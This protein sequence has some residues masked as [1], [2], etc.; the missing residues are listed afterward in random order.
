[1]INELNLKGNELII[2]AIIYG[3]TQD[4][5]SEYYGSLRYIGKALSL[6]KTTVASIINRLIEKNIIERTSESHYLTTGVRKLVQ[7]TKTGTV[8]T[9]N[10]TLGVR[11][12]VQIN[13]NTNNKYNNNPSETS[14]QGNN[15]ISSVIKMFEIV[16]PSISQYYGNKTQRGSAA[17]L[18]KKW[19]LNQIKAVVSILP[20]MN[21]DRYA[22]GKSITPYELEKNLG[23]IKAW[24]DSK[25]TNSNKLKIATISEED[26]NAL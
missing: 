22:K 21:A 17:R 19:T 3:F 15:D 10:R 24:I 9:K 23:F 13:N 2:Y 25:K 20:Q 18:L 6:P 1:M 11:K 26:W 4:E 12:L 14:S 5:E 8:G 16:N 7:G